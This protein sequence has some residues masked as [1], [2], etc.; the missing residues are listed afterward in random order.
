MKLS[1]EKGFS[2]GMTSAIITTL[3]MI[4]GL[5]ASTS[6][7]VAVLGGILVIA[8][9]DA[10]SDALGM[11]ISEESENKHSEKDVWESTFATLLSKFLIAITFAIPFLLTSLQNAVIASVT[12]GF[13]L[14]IFLNYRIARK[15][16]RSPLKIISE[17]LAIAATVI[18]LTH[19]IGGLV[20]GI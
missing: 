8:V 12:W 10:L 3:G 16:K 9:A 17:H 13:L 1:L 15:Q 19:V 18:I 7:Q 6:S 2:F 4:V 14:L 5:N 20:A 11:H